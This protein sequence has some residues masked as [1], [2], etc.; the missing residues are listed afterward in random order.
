MHESGSEPRW[1]RWSRKLMATAQNGL[2]YAEDHFD[3][4]RYQQVRQVAAEM[5]EESGYHTR[6][7]KLLAVWDR[8]K[9]RHTPPYPDHIYKNC[10]SAPLRELI[11][12][13]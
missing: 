7:V 3:R 2:T 4:E 13:R 11:I 12:T 1:I 9:H 5:M 6:A 8:A 10:A